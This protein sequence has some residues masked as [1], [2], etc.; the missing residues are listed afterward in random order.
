MQ[1]QNTPMTGCKVTKFLS[2]VGP[3][4]STGGGFT[5]TWQDYGKS[6]KCS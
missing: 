1:P 2:T 5:T 3:L 4:G 6:E